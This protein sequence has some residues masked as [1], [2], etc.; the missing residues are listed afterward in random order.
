MNKQ[1]ISAA[2]AVLALLPSLAR[3]HPGH[4]AFDFTAGPPHPGHESELG[5]LL[6]ATALTVALVAGARW[7][8]ARRR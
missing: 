2:A 4:S 5:T 3:A 6:I 8:S 1:T 7:V